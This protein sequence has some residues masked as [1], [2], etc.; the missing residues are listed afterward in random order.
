LLQL[1]EYQDTSPSILVELRCRNPYTAKSDLLNVT[2]SIRPTVQQDGPSHAVKPSSRARPDHSPGLPEEIVFRVTEL[3]DNQRKFDIRPGVVSAKETRLAGSSHSKTDRILLNCGTNARHGRYLSRER[4]R[5]SKYDAAAFALAV[6]GK[7]K[8]RNFP[9]S[10]VA[11][12]ILLLPFPGR[13][14]F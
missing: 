2:Q 12:S 6:T 9:V 4:N 13:S 7:Q 5:F 1:D 11:A 3:G 14:S 10:P 8:I